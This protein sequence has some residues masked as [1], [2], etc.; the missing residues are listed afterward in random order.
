MEPEPLKKA[1]APEEPVESQEEEVTRLKRELEEK[2]E[3]LAEVSSRLESV[4]RSDLDAD[5]AK[6]Q[7][8]ID[9]ERT[10]SEDYL[11]RLKYLQAD[12]ENYRRRVD[13]EIRDIE[14]FST[15]GLMRR[16]L[17]VLDDLELAL[18]TAKNSGNEGIVEGI[19][20]VQKNLTTALQAEGLK[21]IEAVG[22]PFDPALHEAVERV[23]APQGSD[24]DTVV[25]EIRK[26]YI[27]K[28]KV[29]RPTMVRVESAGKNSG[30]KQ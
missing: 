8:L 14:E 11:N 13:R 21:E 23:D 12:F 4:R 22:R 25:A 28:D 2:T 10:R 19:G 16:L 17:P 1:A 15:S 26:G 9:E 7:R 30:E 20:M 27:L 24:K 29:L 6:A 3:E 5:L 18:A